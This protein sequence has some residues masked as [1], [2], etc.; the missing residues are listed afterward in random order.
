[1]VLPNF[2]SRTIREIVSSERSE[3]ME[4]ALVQLRKCAGA[5]YRSA[6]RA[7]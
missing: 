7:C 4:E 2:G 1:M 3:L 6:R 5:R